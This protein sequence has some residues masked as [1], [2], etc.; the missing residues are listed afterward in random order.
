MPKLSHTASVPI[1]YLDWARVGFY[2]PRQAPP[3]RSG[4]TP[5]RDIFT[6]HDA[7]IGNSYTRALATACSQHRRSCVKASRYAARP[8]ALAS[9]IAMVWFML[10]CT[11][12]PNIE[13]CVHG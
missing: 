11:H 6:R 7:R 9:R 8:S 12:L 5:A 1:S 13:E 2:V 10:H 3:P 4:V